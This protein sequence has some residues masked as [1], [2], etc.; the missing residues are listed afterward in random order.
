MENFFRPF[1]FGVELRFG[2]FQDLDET[3]GRWVDGFVGGLRERALLLDRI[4]FEIELFE[5]GQE[6]GVC[7]LVS[8]RGRDE[9][10]QTR[11]VAWT[12]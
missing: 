1:L 11:C 3:G 12:L 5:G 7:W 10:I 6:R 2:D 9:K 8:D 4:E